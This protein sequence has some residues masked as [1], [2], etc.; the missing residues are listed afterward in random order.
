MREAAFAKQQPRVRAARRSVRSDTASAL[1][2][3][4]GGDFEKKIP[5]WGI[6]RK[7]ATLLQ[8]RGLP[9]RASGES[10]QLLSFGAKTNVTRYNS[11]NVYSYLL[12]TYAV[13]LLYAEDAEPNR[14]PVEPTAEGMAKCNEPHLRRQGECAI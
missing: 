11:Q 7:R 10:P 5:W 4:V 1:P 9:Q 13:V 12:D 8:S 3:S 2:V 6:Y 14:K